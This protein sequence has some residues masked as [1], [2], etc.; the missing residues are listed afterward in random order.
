MTIK[1]QQYSQLKPHKPGWYLVWEDVPGHYDH[2]GYAD[3]DY[4]DGVKWKFIQS[5]IT[6]WCEITPPP[7]N[8]TKQ[9][10]Q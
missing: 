3:I 7:I 6:W 4:W 10:K 8:R 2:V 1:W 9:R 5:S